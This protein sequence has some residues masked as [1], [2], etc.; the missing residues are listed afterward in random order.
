VRTSF[1]DNQSGA[2]GGGM[3]VFATRLTTMRNCTFARNS[4]LSS[5]ALDFVRPLDSLFSRGCRM[6]SNQLSLLHA[7]RGTMPRVGISSVRRT[8]PEH[9]VLINAEMCC[10]LV[11]D[12]ATDLSL[13]RCT[14]SNNTAEQSGGALGASSI[15]DANLTELAFTANIVSGGVP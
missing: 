6:R 7:T 11:Q 9:C 15:R 14:F 10:T 8:C 5:G 1:T 4:A 12:S 2:S 3:S 13:Q